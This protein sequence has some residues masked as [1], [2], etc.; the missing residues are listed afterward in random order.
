[1]LADNSDMADDGEMLEWFEA[2]AAEQKDAW[3]DACEVGDI[4]EPRALVETLPE[5]RRPEQP[6]QWVRLSASWSDGLIAPA[7][8][9]TWLQRPHMTDH[10]RDFLQRQLHRRRGITASDVGQ[11][12]EGPLH[13][14]RFP[15]WSP[16]QEE[17]AVRG[18]GGG[19]YRRTGISVRENGVTVWVYKYDPDC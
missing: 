17:I 3:L 16:P 13:G 6:A 5:D 14:E 12:E 9:R 18:G 15:L 19:C 2:L 1:M 10:L 11:Y 8:A 7:A 4:V